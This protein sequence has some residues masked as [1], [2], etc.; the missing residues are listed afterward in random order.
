MN[1]DESYRVLGVKPGV[2]LTEARREYYKLLKFFHPDRH[3]GSPGLLRK[4]TEE[5]K[6]LNLAYEQLC[7]VF[8]RGKTGGRAATDGRTKRKETSGKA[9]V[10]GETFTVRS[11]GM[12][13]NWI[14]PGR[15]VMGSPASEAGRSNDEGPQTEVTISRGFW[16]GV[17]AVTQEEWKAIAEEADGLK[18][19]PSYFRGA[20]LPVEQVSWN[21]CRIW[22][23]ELNASEEGR[24]PQGYEYRLP[25]EAEWE[26]VC[27]AGTTTRFCCGE[28]DEVLNDYAWY[29]GNSGSQSHAVGEK[30]PNRWGLF[31][32]H[33][34][35]WEWC[36][37]WYGV[38]GGGKVT[39]PTG[40]SLGMKRVMRGGSWGVAATR[41][42]AAY[43]VWNE[44]GYRDYTL[45]FRVGLAAS[46]DR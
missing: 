11:C 19:E 39:D 46:C 21:E 23:Q 41:C 37:D 32:M 28:G 1:L 17:F 9:P 12:K 22:L 20:R 45:G 6:K 42:R 43:R 33:G 16:L 31:D 7:K 27:R 26:F 3:Q 2:S 8:G 18:V 44:P 35:V 30:K 10:P 38:F 13:M 24:L 36:R 34:N 4:A 15:F 29:N 40:P 25:T 5:T 14:A